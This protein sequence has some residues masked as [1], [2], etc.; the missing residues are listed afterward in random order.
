MEE[1]LEKDLCNR[2]RNVIN[3][4]DIFIKDEE[5]SKKFNLICAIMDRFDS[6]IEYIN[7]HVETPSTE[8]DFI[9]FMNFCCT[10]KD[11]I[12]YII[13]VL[14]LVPQ[15]DNEIFKELYESE[16]LSI[17]PENKLTDDNFFEYFRSL[18]FAHPF[19]TDRS[20]P[21]P[22]EKGEIQYS[23]YVLVDIHGLRKEKNAVG[24]MVYSNKRKDFSIVLS[25][26]TLK[27]YIKWKYEILQ[28]IINE[29]ENIIKAKE[30]E[31]KKHKV[32]RNLPP[33]EIL[34][35]IKEILEERCIDSYQIDE[36]IRNL[37]TEVTCD[38]NNEFVNIFKSKIVE[39][40]P[41]ICNFMD[42]YN[43]EKV[44]ETINNIIGVRPDGYPRMHYQLEKIFVYL[45]D[46][47]TGVNVDW[48]LKQ[49]EEFSKGFAKKWVVI[50]P[51]IMSFDEI[52]L[53]V[54]TACYLEYMEQNKED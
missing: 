50:E 13:K 18:A 48:G 47:N 27:L 54:L 44:S 24:V 16:P 6:A 29:F 9:V 53:L 12:N 20:I 2:L 25:F 45:I 22:I 42:E 52:K 38:D 17:S 10:I 35:D 43:H 26:D 5:E 28:T 46:G 30:E 49:A 36:L 3:K 41:D 4:T 15:N 11:G 34:K 51:Y 40:I 7:N 31:W 37:N 33:I 1:L 19:M 8:T 14:N 21:N 39:V 32:N 23:P